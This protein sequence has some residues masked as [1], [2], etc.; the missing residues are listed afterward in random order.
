VSGTPISSVP[1]VNIS[2]SVHNVTAHNFTVFF[3]SEAL[4]VG[5]FGAFLVTDSNET[6]RMDPLADG[7]TAGNIMFL[8]MDSNGLLTFGDVFVI[9]ISSGHD[10]RF[11]LFWRA[12]DDVV[13]THPWTVP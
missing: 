11:S 12:T 6:D 8:D 9:S 13:D 4:D 2:W 1:G 3:V 7:A 10:Y 5:L